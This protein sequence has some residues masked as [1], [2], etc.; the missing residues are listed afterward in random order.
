MDKTRFGILGSGFMGHTPAEAI[1]GL[2][3]RRPGEFGVV[4]RDS[5]T[6]P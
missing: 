4:C 5:T 2:R 3:E 6:L 1:I